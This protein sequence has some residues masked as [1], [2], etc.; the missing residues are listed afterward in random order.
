MGRTAV[1]ILPA[2]M[3][4]Q[5]QSE[6][7]AAAILVPPSMARAEELRGAKQCCWQIKGKPW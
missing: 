1:P 7:G 5:G 3:I 6:A 2:P 4:V